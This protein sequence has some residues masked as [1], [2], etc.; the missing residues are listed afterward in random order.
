MTISSIGV[1]P[2]SLMTASQPI[3]QASSPQ[4]KAGAENTKQTASASVAQTQQA[5]GASSQQSSP[6]QDQI[7]FNRALL[8]IQDGNVTSAQSIL[9]TLQAEDPSLALRLKAAFPTS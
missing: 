2:V 7:L 1:S 3:S 5:P 9:R 6:S 4:A 8:D